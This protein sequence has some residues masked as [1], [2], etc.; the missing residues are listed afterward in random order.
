MN[1]VLLQ[2]IVIVMGFIAVLFSLQGIHK[3]L[4]A[5]VQYLNAIA[6]NTRP[7]SAADDD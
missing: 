6:Q 1:D 2:I 5:I 7:P 4:L 3:T